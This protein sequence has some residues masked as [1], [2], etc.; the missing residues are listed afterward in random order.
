MGL[1]ELYVSR[2]DAIKVKNALN[3]V[4]EHLEQFESKGSVLNVD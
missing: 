2:D 4:N 1:K 3:Q